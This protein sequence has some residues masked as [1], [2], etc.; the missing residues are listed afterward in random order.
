M[1]DEVCKELATSYFLFKQ[2]TLKF[3]DPTPVNGWSLKILAATI[4]WD[5]H[6]E[7]EMELFSFLLYLGSIFTIRSEPKKNSNSR[8]LILKDSSLIKEIKVKN[9]INKEKIIFRFKP[10]IMKRKIKKFTKINLIN[11]S[12]SPVIIIVKNIIEKKIRNFD[13]L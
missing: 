13:G 9:K 4:Q 2:A 12:L 7:S 8:V 1:H 6:G 5:T 3:L 11:A 10:L